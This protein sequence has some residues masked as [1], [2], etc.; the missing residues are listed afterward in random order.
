MIKHKNFCDVILKL[1]MYMYT[2][3][4]CFLLY[5]L[6]TNTTWVE[7]GKNCVLMSEIWLLNHIEK[8]EI[9]QSWKEYKEFLDQQYI[10]L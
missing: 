9:H 3:D 7:R 8:T 2:Q 1:T 10:E 5:S 4:F 6:S